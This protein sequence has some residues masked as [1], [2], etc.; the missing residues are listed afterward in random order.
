MTDT[1]STGPDPEWLARLHRNVARMRDGGASEDEVNRYLDA[2]GYP[3]AQ[4]SERGV[5]AD[6]GIVSQGLSGF[7]EGVASVPATLLGLPGSLAN[8]PFSLAGVPSEEQPFFGVTDAMRLANRVI[9]PVVT[10]YAPA[11][12]AQRVLRRGGQEVGAAAPFVGGV[13]GAARHLVNNAPTVVRVLTGADRAMANPA[14]FL[15]GEAGSAASGGITAGLARE[16][17]PDQYGLAADLYGSVL[18]GA[19][20]SLALAGGRATMDAAHGLAGSMAPALTRRGAE[21]AAGEELLR[22]SSFLDRDALI[23]EIDRRLEELGPDAIPGYQPTTAQL[24]TDPVARTHR[25][26][27]DPAPVERAA[28]TGDLGLTQLERAYNSGGDTWG[29]FSE[30]RRANEGALRAALDEAAP[31]GQFTPEAVRTAIQR[32]LTEAERAAQQAVADVGG[33]GRSAADASAV[34]RREVDAAYLEGRAEETRL[35]GQV[36]GV[37][38]TGLSGADLQARVD[39]WFGSQSPDVQEFFP[40]VIRRVVNRYDEDATVRFSDLSSLRSVVMR[41]QRSLLGQNRLNDA[42]V[43]GQFEQMLMD[44]ID[45]VAPTGGA[46]RQAW[47]TARTF[48]REFNDMF[49]RGPAARVWQTTGAGGSRVEISDTVREFFR[50]DASRSAHEAVFQLQDLAKT[51]PE[52]MSE[53]EGVIRDYAL[54]FVTRPD[55]TID[56]TR[57]NTFVT[58]HRQALAAFPELQRDLSNVFTAWQAVERL[59]DNPVRNTPADREWVAARMYL[60]QDPDTVM[61]RIMGSS[62]AAQEITALRGQL[63]HDPEALRG[64]QRAFWDHIVRSARIEGDTPRTVETFGTVIRNFFRNPQA[65]SVANLL[66]TS[67]QQRTLQLVRDW[68]DRAN[69]VRSTQVPGS[70]TSQDLGAQRMASQITR[71]A[72]PGWAGFGIDLVSRAV[73]GM[74]RESRQQL[75]VD[76]LLNPEFTRTLLTRVTP[77]NERAIM[78][79]IHNHVVGAGILAASDEEPTGDE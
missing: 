1:E 70:S 40:D 12:V 58:G 68:S 51:N 43:L 34:L 3:Q 26:G 18:G 25:P 9:D 44:L 77:Q 2:V 67:E 53:I 75:I 5:F 15:A 21:R 23:R 62:N 71:R 63:A 13:A 64:L 42:R 22:H 24:L 79:A 54:T 76:A 72:L 35:W 52:R 8:I 47:D 56:P 16:V 50:P 7:N 11:T 55:G 73:G 45:D 59:T 65:R 37:A 57:L 41:E 30:R 39:N 17:A 19:F 28:E 6:G 69:I 66:L 38:P 78:R 74:T 31:D 10:D 20:P 4:A 48:S 14:G 29:Q 33:S 46:A 49:T 27:L 32:R 60:Q 36:D 61:R